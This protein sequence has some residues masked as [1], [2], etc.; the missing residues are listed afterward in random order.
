MS[1]TFAALALVLATGL[2]ACATP[3][4]YAPAGVTRSSSNGYSEQRIEADRWRVAF[5]GNSM[6]S[7]ETVETYLLYRAAEL[8]LQQGNDWFA[9]VQ[10]DTEKKTQTYVD[11]D[12]FLYGP[13]GFGY[14]SPSWRYYGRGFGWR[15]WDPFWGDPFWAERVDVRTVDRFEATAEIVMRR[16]PKPSADPGAFDAR[17]VLD[18]LGPRI[19]RPAPG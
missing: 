4:P 11:H 6:T 9:I 3:T 12:P 7:R 8:T 18:N 16:G 17:A 10:R 2:S 1:K 14:W 19:Q 13:R 15:T 5:S